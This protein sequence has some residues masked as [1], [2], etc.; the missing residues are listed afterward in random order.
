VLKSLTHEPRQSRITGQ[1]YVSQTQAEEKM[2]IETETVLSTWRYGSI[3]AE[4]LCSA[5]LNT[6]GYHSVDPQC[7]LGGPD[8][9]KDVVFSNRFMERLIAGVYFPTTNQEFRSI[10]EKFEHDVDGIAANKAD[11]FYFF[12]NQRISP[13]ERTQLEEIV[14][15]KG[16]KAKIYHLLYILS[17]LDT[18]KYYGIRLEFLRISM[19]PEEQYAFWTTWKDD[20]REVINKNT[21]HLIL[22]SQK[23]DSMMR[24]QS[25]ILKAFTNKA[26]ELSLSEYNRILSLVDKGA[27]ITKT[28]SIN[29]LMFIN[30]IVCLSFDPPIT[31]W[32]GKLRKTA[33]WI[34]PPGATLETAAYIPP[35]PEEI[36]KLIEDLL[37]FWNTNYERAKIDDNENRIRFV[38]EF[39]HRLLA[40][41][42]FLDGNG[43]TAWF[44]L[45]QQLSE[46]LETEVI[47]EVNKKDGTYYKCLNEA[48][49]GNLGPLI[50]YIKDAIA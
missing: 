47:I 45:N 25:T 3:Q 24:T 43:T 32:A 6:E 9:L 46:L 38:A 16:K 26:S 37:A 28:I 34:G 5:I 20:F 17:L 23:V 11:G 40:I 33:V 13:T 8:G 1:A 49:K 4:L 2:S 18:P 42:P 22:L 31:N 44:L 10:K 39:H 30:K 19:N 48:D 14:A 21:D 36:P 7:P 27:E 41:H 12:T 15:A 50:A 29:L 35:Q